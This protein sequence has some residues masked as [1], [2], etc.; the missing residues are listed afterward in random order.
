MAV[1][2]DSTETNS[3]HFVKEVIFDNKGRDRA[4]TKREELHKLGNVEPFM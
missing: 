2:G 4:T 1:E 3:C